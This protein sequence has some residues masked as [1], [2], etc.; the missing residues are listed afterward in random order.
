MQRLGGCD[1]LSVMKNTYKHF[2]IEERDLICKYHS[3]GLS[4][5]EIGRLLGRNKSSISREIKSN[6]S[7]KWGCYLAN[8]AQNK[9]KA[10]KRK[11]GIRPRLKTRM[12]KE[13][14]IR[15]LR[16]GLTPEQISGILRKKTGKNVIS[17]E[18]IYQFIYDKDTRKQFNLVP[19]LARRHRIRYPRWHTR[20]HRK[21]LIPNRVS[22]KE[23]P[24][25]PKWLKPYGQWEADTAGI[26]G[27]GA[28]V[29]IA[30]EKKSLLV[31][32]LKIKKRNSKT[33]RVAINKMLCR[34]PAHMLN[35]LTL[36][37]GKENIEHEL[38]AKTLDIKTFFCEPYH[39]WE[40][41]TVE[42]T[43]SRFRRFYPKKTDFNKVNSSAIKRVERIMNNT[44]RKKL[45]YET[46]L[47]IFN[48]G[49]ALPH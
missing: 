45:G 27:K 30:V 5:A 44:P 46:P 10:R 32:L 15:S 28:K 49:V 13:K 1:N 4:K 18:A 17:P 22:I 19:C 24:I 34:Y 3:Q 12:I 8:K 36:D 6:G 21:L 26:T 33:F 23:R 14:V 38:I 43:L 37:N 42:N 16:K 31:K 48:A 35:T 7:P 39:S 20:R 9:A 29:V 25:Y 47:K 11:A 40:K 2:S 41:A